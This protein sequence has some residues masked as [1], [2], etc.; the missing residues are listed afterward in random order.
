[1][2]C[3]GVGAP[4]RSLRRTMPTLGPSRTRQLGPV[5]QAD[6]PNS[7]SGW[8][9]DLGVRQLAV[10]PGWLSEEATSRQRA[11]RSFIWARISCV[12][13]SVSAKDANP[14]ANPA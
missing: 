11:A 9:A 12:R 1:M 8:I 5:R 7:W 4:K 13:R 14:L 3:F 10:T 2:A 6:L